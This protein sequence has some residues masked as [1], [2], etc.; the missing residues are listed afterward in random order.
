VKNAWWTSHRRR[1]GDETNHGFPAQLA[2]DSVA[3]LCCVL[4]G[5][6]CGKRYGTHSGKLMMVNLT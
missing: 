2:F 6:V 4:L 1:Q 3:A 5:S